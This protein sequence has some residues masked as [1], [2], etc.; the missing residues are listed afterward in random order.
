[1]NTN[2]DSYS[3][4]PLKTLSGVAPSASLVMCWSVHLLKS[5]KYKF[6]MQR[7]GRQHACQK[8]TTKQIIKYHP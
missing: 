3:T 4:N 6:Q 5:F 7:K 2:I 1:M 8:C